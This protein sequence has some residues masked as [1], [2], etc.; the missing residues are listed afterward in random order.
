MHELQERASREYVYARN[1]FWK[2][3][4][5]R[6]ATAANTLDALMARSEEHE[7]DGPESDEII[8]EIT[9]NDKAQVT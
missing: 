4:W 8:E 6:L 1:P 9:K 2:A 7:D 5:C 3:G